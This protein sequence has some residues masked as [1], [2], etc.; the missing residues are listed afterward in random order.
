MN[1]IVVTGDGSA[2]IYSTQFGEQYHSKHGAWSES[3]YVFIQMGLFQKIH[4]SQIAVFE[5]GFG[6]GL[7]LLLTLKHLPPTCQLYYETVEKFP[8]QNTDYL[9]YAEF[10]SFEDRPLFKRLHQLDWN[11]KVILNN[12]VT[13]KKVQ[14]DIYDYQPS[15]PFDLIY[16]DA[17][18]PRT[19]PECWS[20]SIFDKLYESMVNDGILVTYCAK[21]SIKRLLTEVGFK[22][23]TLPGPLYKREMIR[24]I[25]SSISI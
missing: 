20:K 17:F 9:S 19:Q 18:S 12:Q 13:I 6:S 11:Q 2:S 3:L 1:T 25:K 22:V 23:Q 10:V 21:G 4:Q 5:M 16:F 8:L 14:A 7:N 15:D 24:T